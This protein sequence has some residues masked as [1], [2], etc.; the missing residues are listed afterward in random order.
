MPNR[1]AVTLRAMQ[2]HTRVGILA[3]ERELPQPVEVDVTVWLAPAG[4]SAGGAATVLD[5][6]DLYAMAADVLHGEPRYLEEAAQA[7]AAGALGLP[8][9]ERV[10]VAVRKPHVPLPGPLAHA[11]VVVERDRR[12]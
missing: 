1:D 5:Y 3:H 10:R 7:I 9:A 6:R 2:F 11:E 8:R 12:A 4:A